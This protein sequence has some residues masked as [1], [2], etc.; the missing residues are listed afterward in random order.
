[1][2]GRFIVD[3]KWMAQVRAED[4]AAIGADLFQGIPLSSNRDATAQKLPSDLVS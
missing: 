4:Q 3:W 1:M 2:G